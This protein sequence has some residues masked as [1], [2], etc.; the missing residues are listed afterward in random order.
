MHKQAVVEAVQLLQRSALRNRNYYTA[1]SRNRY[2]AC[3]RNCHSTWNRNYYSAWNK[4]SSTQF[5]CNRT[6]SCN[7][8]KGSSTSACTAPEQ[9]EEEEVVVVVLVAWVVPE[10]LGGMVEMLEVEV[11]AVPEEPVVV[12]AEVQAVLEE[13]EVVEEVV[14]EVAVPMAQVAAQ[15]R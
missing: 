4:A 1:C 3:N 2:S 13:E 7:H 14:E 6:S 8:C 10:G 15:K 12:Q 9:E 5:P 11:R